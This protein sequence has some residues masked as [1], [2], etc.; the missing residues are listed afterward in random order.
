MCWMQIDSNSL[1][2]MGYFISQVEIDLFFF[3]F[4]ATVYTFENLALSHQFFIIIIIVDIM[5]GSIPVSDH[6]IQILW[7]Q[8]IEILRA[9]H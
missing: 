6:G 1:L 7:K 2:E 9:H 8:S 5:K 4:D 3:F